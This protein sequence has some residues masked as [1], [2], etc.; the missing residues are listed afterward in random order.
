MLNRIKSSAIL[1]GVIC[2]CVWL[3]L[4]LGSDLPCGLVV[5]A[6]LALGCFELKEI[7]ARMDAHL[8]TLPLLA[9][10]PLFLL[11]VRHDASHP[12][13]RLCA[14]VGFAFF[15]FI[16]LSLLSR[17]DC[18]GATRRLALALFAFFYI[19]V[20]GSFLYRI[21]L[22]DGGVLLLVYA[23]ATAKISDIGALLVGTLIGRKK[24]IP[25]ISPAK[26]FEGLFGGVLS[27]ALFAYATHGSLA[28][29][30]FSGAMAVLFGVAITV[31]A[32]GGDLL[33]SMIKR[34]AG[35][36]DSGRLIPG[37]GGTLDILDSLLL[38]AP[39]AYLLFIWS[40]G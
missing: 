37:L 23:V 19:V 24:L 36:K 10:I 25:W 3:D 9:S 30:Y 20:L 16:V 35:V 4:H 40:R 17:K 8:P 33:E 1:I 34:D 22:L 32:A 21:R 2:G 28:K 15:A 29:G 27:G 7:C 39:V 13:I 31:T 5:A 38:S 11:A 12:G 6:F 18:G 14:V 26:T